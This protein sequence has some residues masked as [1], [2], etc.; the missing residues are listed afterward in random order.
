MYVTIV[1]IL[2]N[3]D[4]KFQFHEDANFSDGFVTPKK[5][6]KKPLLGKIP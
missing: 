6:I 3:D 1:T 5:P 4:V 2:Y